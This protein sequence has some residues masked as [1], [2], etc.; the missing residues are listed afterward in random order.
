M[1]ER[2]FQRMRHLERPGLGKVYAMQ[3][4]GFFDG[5]KSLFGRASKT[6]LKSAKPIAKSLLKEL[7]PVALT[8]VTSKAG[9]ALAKQGV[10]DSLINAGSQLAQRGAQTLQKRLDAPA[11]SESQKQVKN[12]ISNNSQSLLADLIARK[13]SGV[14]G[15]GVRPLGG[16]VRGLGVRPL[17]GGVRGLGVRPLGGKGV[18]LQEAP[19]I[20]DVPR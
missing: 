17:G 13:G 15:L 9:E 7:A 12:F 10:P 2:G 11:L 16:G 8:T 1:R 5:V 6:L 4:K 18:T 14:R 19:T 20:Y 3:G